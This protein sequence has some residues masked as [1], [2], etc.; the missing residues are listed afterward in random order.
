MFKNRKLTKDSDIYEYNVW[1]NVSITDEMLSKALEKICLDNN[2]KDTQKYEQ[3]QESWEKFYKKHNDN[4]FKDRK[5]IES[6]F[7]EIKRCKKILEIGCGVGNSLAWLSKDDENNAK[8]VFG[9]DFSTNAIKIARKRFTSFKFFVHDICSDTS[10]NSDINVL[11]AKN[12]DLDKSLLV[13]HGEHTDFDC[14]ILIF[15]LSAIDPTYYDK[16][17][18]KIYNIL[19][20]GGKV[21]FKDYSFLDMIQ[22]R[23]K[24][25]QIVKENFYKRKDGTF[26]HFFMLN[27]LKDKFEKQ[28]F[29]CESLFE[30]K[31]MKVNRKEKIEMY[32]VMLQGIFVK[33]DVK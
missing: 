32:R 24:S 25:N 26:T 16:I 12:D 21:Y 11:Y 22:I 29:T 13:C 19:K 9:C 1:D 7:D 4:F 5:W 8:E 6:E 15:T 3:S 20:P 23:Y 17:L 18:T 31:R 27:A 30:D 28:G 2:S 10:I 14:V 33:Q